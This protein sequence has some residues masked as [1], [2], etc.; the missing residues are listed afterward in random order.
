MAKKSTPA[1][2]SPPPRSS[3]TLTL[4]PAQR[5]ALGA[6]LA[7]GPYLDFPVDYAEYAYKG[8]GLT[9][10]A[11][12][13][14]KLVVQGKKT[15]DFV[16]DVLEP[17]V[18][19]DPRLG[20]DAVH[21]PEWF[22]AHAGLDESGKGDFF[23]PLVVACVAVGE[24][25][26]PK[27]I[28][29]G[30]RDSK[31]VSSDRQVLALEKEIRK[32][33]GVVVKTVRAG[34]EKYNELHGKFGANTNRLLAW[35]HG[36]ALRETLA[37]M[38]VPW[39]LLDQFTKQ[40]L[41]QNQVKDLSVEVRMRPRAE[42]D[43]VVAAAS[44]VARAE[45]VRQMAELSQAAGEDLLRGASREVRAQAVRLVERLG[46]GALPRFAKTHFRTAGQVLGE[47]KASEAS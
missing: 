35:M 25:V 2:K 20:Y 47:A 13:S 9:V 40:P 36:K 14:G 34:M 10:V 6:I 32:T 8:E 3:Y 24:G 21:H 5:E 26:V 38:P 15:E 7:D 17:R 27:W 4:E 16:R 1:R 12:R 41:V 37:E 29:A 31:S 43:P 22:E 30:I 44:I 45:Y 19:G 42:S 46:P 11:Y 23:G 39:A 18:T 33:P 28:E